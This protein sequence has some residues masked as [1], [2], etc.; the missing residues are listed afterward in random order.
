MSVLGDLY[1]SAS[2]IEK[3]TWTERL[4]A[5]F[6]GGYQGIGLRP[7]HYKAAI[8]EGRTDADLRAM[9]DERGLEVIEIGFVAN[10][11]DAP[12]PDSR[13]YG[14][15]NALFRLKEALGARHMM[16]I[17]GPLTDGYDAV[18]ERF[19]GV[20][21]RAAE[22]GLRVALE[23]LPWTDMNDAGKAWKIVELAGRSNGG[24]V[25]DTWHH[26]RGPGT[27]DMLRAIPPDHIVTVQISDGQF[28]AV[29]D[30]LEDTFKRR[31]LPGH[32]EFEIIKLVRLIEE[33]GVTAPVGIEVLHDEL[34]KLPDAEVARL[35]ADATREVLAAA[36]A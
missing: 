5:A 9:L 31:L 30:E 7:S 24:V 21:D 27:D 29:G 4:D 28:E 10:W 23:F 14:H 25:L 26:N 6:A 34:R 19:A 11:W 35:G 2:T 13:L 16:L 36:H 18:A 1:L 8:A 17:G 32:G 3:A 15:E 33:L 12:T 20:C 22:H